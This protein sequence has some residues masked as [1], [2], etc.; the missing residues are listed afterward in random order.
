MSDYIFFNQRTHLIFFPVKMDDFGMSKKLVMCND[1]R[2]SSRIS[3]VTI[4]I[5]PR[6]TSTRCICSHCI[7]SRRNCIEL[8]DR[9]PVLNP[10]TEYLET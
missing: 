2:F 3:G 6:R 7:A 10:I 4:F 5:K 1:I 9:D 8:V